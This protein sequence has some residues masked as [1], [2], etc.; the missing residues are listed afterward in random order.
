MVNL[1]LVSG[2]F[3]STFVVWEKFIFYQKSKTLILSWRIFLLAIFILLFSFLL[4]NESS[5]M[6]S[7][8]TYVI[9]LIGS[10]YFSV[11]LKWVAYLN[12]K[13][14]WKSILLF[15]LVMVYIVFFINRILT[16]ANEGDVIIFDLSNNHAL[17]SV[18]IFIFIYA[19]ISILVILFNL[20]TSSVFEKKLEEIIN[21]QRLSQSRNT[22][23]N[24][25]QVYEILLESSVSAVL[26]EAAWLELN[27]LDENT[28]RLFTYRINQK[29]IDEVREKLPS[30]KIKKLLSTDPVKNVKSNRY[31][32]SLKNHQYKSILVFPIFAQGEPIGSLV[33]LKELYDG[34]NDD[35][36]NVIATFVNQASISVE[37]YR[38][39]ESAVENEKYKKELNI[40]K[41][42]QRSL[43]PESLITSN[44]FEVT[45]VSRSAD[46]VGGDYYDFYKVHDDKV[47]FIIGDVSGKGT[48]A[49][50]HMSQLKGIFHSLVQL[51]LSPKEFL[52]YANNALAFGLD[53]NSFIT[54]S[55]YI[56]DN[57]KK[58]IQF[59]RAGHCPTLY[60]KLKKS[61][62]DFYYG[63][64]LGLG[65]LRNNEFQSYVNID[66]IKYNVG[67][68]LVL[69]TD[70]ITEAKNS[71]N[72]EF[73]YNRLK[74]LIEQNAS[75]S[76]GEIKDIVFRELYEY[77]GSNDPKDDYTLIIIKFTKGNN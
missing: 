58:E 4:T 1:G 75:H 8:P 24:E 53:K 16:Y 7:L 41:Y 35:M 65:I 21:F 47:V 43:L 6:I 72:E 13:Q 56:I 55:Y 10:I 14:K 39:I 33:L 64:G 68:L 27:N 40:A 50:F 62:A 29:E 42:V 48:S 51:N 63:K 49:A 61:K 31:I 26:A 37:N 18:T 17:A 20:P 25:I 70:G 76:T 28:H 34:F 46:E 60:Y 32:A 54:T 77:C 15:L 36:I 30:G 3:V 11:N 73:G 67:D 74:N 44:F 5:R 52:V 23:K 66:T 69:F 71:N 59:S 9:I 2:F 22:G 57:F 12:F 19:F 38:L 45:G